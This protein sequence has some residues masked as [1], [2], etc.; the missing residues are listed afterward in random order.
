MVR[1]TAVVELNS[2]WMN[3]FTRA[4]GLRSRSPTLGIRKA[5]YI[6]IAF[7]PNPELGDRDWERSHPN[8]MAVT[9]CASGQR[10]FA[11]NILNKMESNFFLNEF[12]RCRG[13][14]WT[15][16]EFHGSNGNGFGDIW[17]TDN[18]IYLSSIDVHKSVCSLLVTAYKLVCS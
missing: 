1:R 5:Q 9:I 13:N 16:C 8:Q 10:R 11:E 7:C 17:W 18:P 3:C 6:A 12:D 4:R 14:T 2:D 15:V